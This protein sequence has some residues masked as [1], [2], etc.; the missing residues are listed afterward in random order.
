MGGR[1][2]SRC[3]KAGGLQ[4]NLAGF[5]GQLLNLNAELIS[6]ISYGMMPCSR[7]IT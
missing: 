3:R 5:G 7:D 1:R 4:A 2:Y 6:L